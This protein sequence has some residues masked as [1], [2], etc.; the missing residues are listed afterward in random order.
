MKLQGAGCVVAAV[1]GALFIVNVESHFHK[2]E[3]QLCKAFGEPC[4]SYD[5]RST[6]G[7]RCWFKLEFPREKC[8]N[9]NGKR[10][11]PIDIPDVKS[12][13]KV[14]QKLR[15]SSRKFVGHL[16]NTGIQP[17]FKRKVGADKVY[18]EGIGSPV[19]KRYFIENVHFHVGVRHKERQTENTLN[20]RSF[21]G[22]AHIVHIREDFGDLKE[23]ANHPQGLLVISIFLSTSKGERRRDG[24]D[25]L[26]EMIQDVQE[27][28]EEDGPCANVKIPDI[29]KFKQ[30][31]PFHPVWPICKKTFP[32]AD[33]SDNSG[34]GVVC[35][36]YLPN[37]L[38]GEKKESKINPN[39]LLADDPEYYVFNGGLTTPPCSESVLWLVAKQPRKVSVFYP[40]VVRNMETQREGEIIGD[41]GNLRPLQ[42]LNDRPVF[43]VRFRL[44]RNWEHGDTAA[45]DNDAMDS[46][47]SVLG[48]N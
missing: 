44:K 3:L 48:I 20:G 33:D 41:F 37:G 39:E 46:P 29:F 45:N 24:F 16:E 36:F 17:A 35:N 13:Y 11:S 25:D 12:I 4:I 23:A 30:L 19:G 34:S 2:P 21:D 22:E 9:E 18:L 32:V 28:E 31:I 5:V 1:L 27:F 15:Y 40:Y 42:D 14:P 10:Q 8:C 43:L 47:F 26:I 38:C 6:I 7:P